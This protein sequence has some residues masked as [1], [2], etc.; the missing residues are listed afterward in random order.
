MIDFKLSYHNYEHQYGVRKANYG[1]PRLCPACRENQVWRMHRDGTPLLC[2]W[3]YM[4]HCRVEIDDENIKKDDLVLLINNFYLRLP[5]WFRESELD[6]RRG[7]RI[8]EWFR[9][10]ITLLVSHDGD[11]E[12]YDDIETY[13]PPT[14]DHITIPPRSLDMSIQVP[15]CLTTRH[16]AVVAYKFCQ[17]IQELINEVVVQAVDHGRNILQALAEGVVP[18]GSKGN[19]RL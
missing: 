15:T 10:F 9:I 1:H 18:D 14:V 6:R 16:Q 4:Q 8:Y 13:V 17:L 3:C 19:Y 7:K 11:W 5:L 12:R 2:Q